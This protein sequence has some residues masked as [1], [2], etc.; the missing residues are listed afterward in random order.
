MKGWLL[1]RPLG[2]LLGLTVFTSVL[3][4]AGC[5]LAYGPDEAALAFVGIMR[6]IGYMLGSLGHIRP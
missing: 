2:W 4:L 1:L 6:N 3:T 5:Y